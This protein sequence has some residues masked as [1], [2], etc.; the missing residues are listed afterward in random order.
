MHVHVLYFF[1][2]DLYMLQFLF[3]LKE[4]DLLQDLLC[5]RVISLDFL[6]LEKITF[7]YT[8]MPRHLKTH[9]LCGNQTRP[10]DFEER[11]L[12]HANET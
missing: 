5:T 3:P 8:S 6:V 12:A 1:F 7:A 4:V 10:L 11:A 9:G 2:W